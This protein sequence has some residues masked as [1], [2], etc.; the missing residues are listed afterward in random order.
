MLPSAP[1]KL[2]GAN[3]FGDA[4][5]HEPLGTDV[6]M[7][8]YQEFAVT[9]IVCLY[10]RSM[11]SVKNPSQDCCLCQMHEDYVLISL[12]LCIRDILIH[13]LTDSVGNQAP[14]W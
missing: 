7:M 4:C 11:I 5:L 13:M 1:S 14:T 8:A 2:D 6:N 12:Q 9:N 10:A 3:R